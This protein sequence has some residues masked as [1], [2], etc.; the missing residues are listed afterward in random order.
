MTLPPAKLGKGGVKFGKGGHRQM[1]L[2]AGLITLTLS[3]KGAHYE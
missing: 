2:P 3:G 1:K